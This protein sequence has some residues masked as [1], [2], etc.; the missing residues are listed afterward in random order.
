MTSTSGP[1]TPPERPRARFF[2]RFTEPIADMAREKFVQAEDKV[3]SA[4]QTE[5]DAVT[6]SVRARAIQVRPSAIAFAAAAVV[7]VLGL[8]MIV[9]AAHLGLSAAIAPWLSAL[10][11]GLALVGIAAGLAAWGRHHL[12]ATPRIEPARTSTHPAEEQVHPWA[13]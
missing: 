8:G 12:P 4:I 11:I 1:D 5:I 6:A 3:R 7:T 10:L 2:D 13:D 9:L